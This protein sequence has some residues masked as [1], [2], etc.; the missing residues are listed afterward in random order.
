[1]VRTILIIVS[2]LLV[3]GCR[4]ID[5]PDWPEE[6]VRGE[7]LD[8]EGLRKKYPQLQ[9][10]VI[11]AKE[12]WEEY[13]KGLEELE[14]KLSPGMSISIEVFEEPLLSRTLFIRPDGKVDLP[15]IGEITAS[16]KTIYELKAE[17]ISKLK[18][19]VKDPHVIV[20]TVS[21]GLSLGPPEITGGRIVV[22]G[23]SGGTGVSNINY[24]GQEKL[25]HIISGLSPT[26][27]WRSIRVIRPNP[28][29][30]KKARIIIC[31]FFAFAKW[32]DLTQ[33]IPV[34]PG[35][36][37]VVPQRWRPNRQFDRDLALIL[38]YLHGDPAALD[39]LVKF[40]EKKF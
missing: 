19:Y 26:A 37:I 13:E 27:E 24:T 34:R 11:S 32:G 38:K 9:G 30:P 29:N 1:M 4:G 22:F 18:K 17:I 6:I 14:Y 31:D 10:I 40:W 2:I 23:A 39:S 25:S 16:G 12:W 15:L 28:K 36:V 33:D 20:N 7:P 3:G 5:P 35:D 8:A 21:Q